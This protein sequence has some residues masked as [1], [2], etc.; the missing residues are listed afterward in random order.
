MASQNSPLSITSS[1][2]GMLISVTD[3]V[4]VMH[5]RF[6]YLPDADRSKDRSAHEE[7]FQ[8]Y[9]S[10]MKELVKFEERLL[11]L[12]AEAELKASTEDDQWKKWVLVPKSK[13]MR[14]FLL[15]DEYDVIAS[16]RPRITAKKPKKLDHK[17]LDCLERT[18][19]SQRETLDRLGVSGIPIDESSLNRI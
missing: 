12:V 18:F 5:V 14:E 1:V 4:A 15:S 16:L 3:V 13:E 10:M 9:M 11:E 8:I 6:T 17:R 7:E 2:S 19:Y